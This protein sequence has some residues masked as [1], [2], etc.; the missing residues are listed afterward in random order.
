MILNPIHE[1]P[2]SVFLDYMHRRAIAPNKTKIII[3]LGDSWFSFG[4]FTSNLLMAIDKHLAELGYDVLIVNSAYPGDTSAGENSTIQGWEQYTTYDA[5]LF[6]YGGNDLIQHLDEVLTSGAKHNKFKEILANMIKYIDLFKK[7]NPSAPVLLNSYCYIGAQQRNHITQAG[8]W[9]GP[10]LR[11]HNLP[12][13]FVNALLADY[14]AALVDVM[15]P[16]YSGY[17]DLEVINTLSALKIP[18]WANSLWRKGRNTEHW[19]NE[20]HPSTQ[21]Y[22]VLAS[23]YWVPALTSYWR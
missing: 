2:E 12:D 6:S 8:P 21:G 14:K 7:R 4:G 13:K 18:E 3:A 23:K 17:H 15:H 9:V 5:M 16:A 10:Q 22:D 20:I 11:A 19:R 1:Y